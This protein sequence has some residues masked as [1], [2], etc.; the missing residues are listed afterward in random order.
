MGIDRKPVLESRL[1]AYSANVK[2]STRGIL[3]HAAEHWPKYAA[4]AGS[5]VAMA[6]N[7][8]AQIV[9]SGPQ[10]LTASVNSVGPLHSSAPPPQYPVVGLDPAT[11]AH[12]TAYLQGSI[13]FQIGVKQE[14][15]G[16]G[17]LNGAASVKGLG[18][19]AFLETGSQFSLRKLGKSVNI[20]TLPNNFHTGPLFL[21]TVNFGTT[22]AHNTHGAWTSGKSGFGA[23]RFTVGGKQDYGWVRLI[24]TDSSN[25]APDSI[26][27]ID[28]AY[29]ADGTPIITD[30][31]S[32]TP[33]PSTADLALLAAGALGV[34]ALRRRKKA[35]V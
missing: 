11:S 20:S 35:T 17:F 7:A 8:A 23:F 3:K 10:N 2:S 6:T 15:C 4:A 16:D 22:G 1:Y 19:L 21:K 26:T 28:W 5:V 9:Y 29:G 18:G 33:E 13:G 27:A 31:P 25:G 30:V 24:Y 12:K 34:L 32:A 14:C